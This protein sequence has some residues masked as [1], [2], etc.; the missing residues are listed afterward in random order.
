V[1]PASTAAVDVSAATLTQL[2]VPFDDH[3][4]QDCVSLR[5]ALQSPLRISIPLNRSSIL[6][7]SGLG[8][9]LSGVFAASKYGDEAKYL[10]TRFLAFESKCFELKSH[11]GEQFVCGCITEITGIM[12]ASISRYV[13][14]QSVF[15]YQYN[16]KDRSGA[17]ED[18]GRPDES[19]YLNDFMVCKSEHKASGIQRAI[20][21]LT[22]KLASYNPMEYGGKILYLPVIAA[23]D[24]LVEIGLIDV[25][26]SLYYHVAR[27]DLNY[28]EHR[29]TCFVS[30]INIFRL[31]RTMA[32]YIPS[33]PAPI[34]PQRDGVEF[35]RKIASCEF[36]VN[37][38]EL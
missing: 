10:V 33:T 7:G 1:A 11:I 15:S 32:S 34:F 36:E 19:D 17:T 22:R 3:V 21:A 20:D 18:N 38:Q 2:C 30:M 26:T 8:L 5:D 24:T 28:P 31:I 35:V 9:E 16:Q 29:V 37:N 14:L 23:A 12:W 4:L 6:V 25:R 13:G 27:H